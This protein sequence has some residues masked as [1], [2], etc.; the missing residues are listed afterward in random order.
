MMEVCVNPSFLNEL[1]SK[2]PALPLFD[3]SDT[4]FAPY[5]RV[6]DFDC[7]ELI[8]ALARQP[9]PDA[10]NAYAASVP[11]LEEPQCIARIGY[12]VF[13]GMDFQAGCCNGRG[14]RLNALE[15]HKCSEVNYSTTG[16]V[17]LMALQS[18]ITNGKLEA[19][20]V[21]GFY[22]PPGTLIEVYPGTLHFAPCDCTGRGF[23]CLVML[24]NGVNEPL[25][26]LCKSAQDERKLLWMRGKWLLCHPD[27][28]QAEKGACVGIDGENIEL[29]I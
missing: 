21:V 1:K 3:V 17:L 6:L 18:D 5:G 13:G 27:S 22:L 16:C 25:P 20:C 23:N 15:Y 12:A 4:R 8:D 7:H 2:N 26:Q 24:E 9:I 14:R 11:E 28:P 29:K 19:S 10:G